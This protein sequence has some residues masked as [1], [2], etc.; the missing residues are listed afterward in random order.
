MRKPARK[1]KSREIDELKEL[2]EEL[3]KQINRLETAPTIIPY[4]VY[5]KPYPHPYTPWYPSSPFWYT[6]T[7]GTGGVSLTPS[8][9]SNVSFKVNQ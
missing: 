9:T 2:V 4:P 1:T 5:P 8:S 7:A 6:N 3:R